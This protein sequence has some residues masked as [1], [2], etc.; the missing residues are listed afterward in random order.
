MK[1]IAFD[2]F[3]TVFDLSGVDRREIVAY[4]DH[5]SKPNWSPL[6]LPKSWETLPAFPDAYEGLSRLRKKFTVVT[7]SNAPFGFT[8][9]ML[10]NASLHFDAITPLEMFEVYKPK[11]E[12]YLAV[13]VTQQVLPSEI[14]MVTGNKQIGRNPKGDWEYAA[15]L[16]MQ[17]ILIRQNPG[18]T[19]IE[20]AEQLGC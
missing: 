1:V 18:A 20:L 5:I 15:E 17:G 10:K 8:T 3:G 6:E 7:C 16:G 2:L 11:P 19:I 4:I 9:R 14:V 13:S 12:A